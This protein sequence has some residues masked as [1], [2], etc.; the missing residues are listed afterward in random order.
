MAIS[1]NDI[2]DYLILTFP[3]LAQED[4]NLREKH[5]KRR[6]KDK[7]IS[8]QD[9]FLIRA[10]NGA[11]VAASWIFKA[12]AGKY[13]FQSPKFQIKDAQAL[14]SLLKEVKRRFYQLKGRSL[15]CRS[16]HDESHELLKKEM[17]N[18]GFS[19]KGDRVEYKTFIKDLPCFPTRSS[20]LKWTSPLQDRS[21][22]IDQVANFMQEVAASDPDYDP[23][24]ENARECLES[25]LQEEGLYTDK[26][27][28][29]IAYVNN[30]PCALLIAQ[31]EPSTGWGTITYMGVH[32]NFRRQG[33]GAWV[34][35]QG[36]E[37]LR[38]QGGLE[39]HGGTNF[40]NLPMRRV[41]EKNGCKFFRKMTEWKL[42]SV[43]KKG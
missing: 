28:I 6:I 34:Q 36:I 24:L 2:R 17:F 10:E 30:I 16:L 9:Y 1:K 18:A 13:A 31:A 21:M 4:L 41:F 43:S 25:Y 42:D 19:P 32:P 8:P 15:M 37:L 27:C 39:Y 29:Q 7:T 22:N 40:N 26:D 38:K 35:R 5:F 33:L 3:N 23:T 12:E 11:P 14:G 20:I